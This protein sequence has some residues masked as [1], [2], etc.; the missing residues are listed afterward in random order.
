M[1]LVC[2][3]ILSRWSFITWKV[4]S[5][6]RLTDA[7]ESIIMSRV[8]PSICSWQVGGCL[9]PWF[10]TEYSYSYS[11]PVSCVMCFTDSVFGGFVL[12]TRTKWPIF[13]QSLQS[14]VILGSRQEVLY[15]K[16]PPQFL[17]FCDWLSFLLVVPRLRDRERWWFDC[18]RYLPL[19]WRRL[20]RDLWNS[21]VLVV[22]R[23]YGPF[24]FF[25]FTCLAFTQLQ[26]SS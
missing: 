7:P 17:Q 5:S 3:R 9:F 8:F 16:C 18:E 19:H 20:C 22:Y 24:I 6:I 26:G 23:I 11:S 4:V 25:N 21:F 1:L 12:Q 13:P 15:G 10:L 14:L 2:S